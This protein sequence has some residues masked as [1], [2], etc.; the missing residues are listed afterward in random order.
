MYFGKYILFIVHAGQPA[1]QDVKKGR[2][3]AS[4][5]HE[6]LFVIITQMRVKANFLFLL[7]K[8]LRL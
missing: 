1:G 3:S 8:S 6:A 4:K 5:W 7:W 2:F